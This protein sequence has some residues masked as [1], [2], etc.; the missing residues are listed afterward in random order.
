MFKSSRKKLIAIGCSFTEHH[1]SSTISP[2]ID[3]DFTRWPKHL[4]N[5][6]DME[7]INLGKCGAGN[8]QILARTL[9]ATLKEKDIG[10][11]VVMWSEWRRVGFNCLRDSN[12]WV[13]VTPHDLETWKISVL[14]KQEPYVVWG[15]PDVVRDFTFSTDFAQACLDVVEKHSVCDPINIGCGNLITIGEA[16]DLILKHT[17]HNVKPVYDTNKPVTIQ[18]RA[19]NTDKAKKILNYN[20][21]V[22]F[23]E[24]IKKTIEWIRKEMETE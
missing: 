8:D 18:Y 4:S 7:C 21:K 23:E 19:L 20:P 17:G 2:D 13:Q 15:N 22:S 5:M 1:L 16:V 3:H 9:D 6:F 12:R 10:L 14:E 24:G 11:V